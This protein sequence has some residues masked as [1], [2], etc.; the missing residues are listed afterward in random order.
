MHNMHA[1]TYLVVNE[2]LNSS[3]MEVDFCIYNAIC[4]VFFYDAYTA[5][6][7]MYLIIDN[8]RIH[9]SVYTLLGALVCV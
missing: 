6:A 3:A 9:N 8:V 7:H 4:H 2:S 1:D 5:F